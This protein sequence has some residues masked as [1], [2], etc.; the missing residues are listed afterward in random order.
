MSRWREIENEKEEPGF[1]DIIS[2]ALL[3]WEPVATPRFKS[4]YYDEES[5]KTVTGYGNTLEEARKNA[6]EKI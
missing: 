2:G 1:F 5:G 4:V 3:P 6:L